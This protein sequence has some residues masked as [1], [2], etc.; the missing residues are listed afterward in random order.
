MEPGLLLFG[1]FFLLLFAGVPILTSIGI[2][3]LL[4]LWQFNLGIQV[5]AANVYANIAKFPLLAIPFFILAGFVMDRVGLSRGLVNL[6]NLLIGPIPGGLGLVAVGGCVLFGAISGTGPADT[7]AIGTVM[8]PAMVKRGY[9]VGFAAALVAAAATTDVLIPPSVAFV[10]YGVITDTS[11]GRLFAAGIIP[12]LLMGLALVVPVYLIGKRRGWGGERWGTW[13][14]IRHAAWEAKWGLLAPVVVLGGIYGG[15]FTPTE[16]AV[17]AVAYGIVIGVG[18]YGNL[19]WRDLYE[20]FRG[21]AVA[22]AVV[23]IVVAFAGLFSWTGATLGVMDRAAKA[24][25]L[26]T[27]N[28][29]LILLLLNLMLVIAGMLLDAISIYYVFLP[30]L[31]PLMKQFNWDPIWFGVVMTVNLAIGTITPPVAVNLYVA[32]NISKTSMEEVSRWVLPFFLALLVALLLITYIP[33]L[34]LWLP[35]ILGIR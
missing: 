32:S 14:E 10:V 35:D 3:S 6:L 26:L 20:V 28:P 31:I 5:T 12:G 17:V 27:Q 16:A 2:A 34:S 25:L 24:I 13:P 18:V 22:T 8:I 15:I 23:M 1:L 30:I 11:I 33:A 9:H 4:M 7:A 29:Y 19:G 21:A